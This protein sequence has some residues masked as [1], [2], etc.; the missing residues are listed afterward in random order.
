MNISTNYEFLS[1]KQQ[2]QATNNIHFQGRLP[3]FKKINTNIDIPKGNLLTIAAFAQLFGISSY[4]V[5]KGIENDEIKLS[6]NKIDPNDEENKNFVKNLLTKIRQQKNFITSSKK[7]ITTKLKQ[8]DLAKFLGVDSHSIEWHIKKGHLILGEDKTIDIT[9]PKNKSFI[10]NFKKFSKYKEEKQEYTVNDYK[11]LQKR[12]GHLQIEYCLKHQLLTADENGTINIENAINKRFL[13]LIET[14][15]IS[16]KNYFLSINE[17]AKITGQSI[18]TITRAL[19]KKELV[20]EKLG[21]D[22][23]NPQNRAF[24][25]KNTDAENKTQELK[26][27]SEIAKTLGYTNGSAIYYY[28]NLG[29]LIQE[30][31]GLININKEPNK[32]FLLE[33]SINKKTRK[34]PITTNKT[35]RQKVDGLKDGKF[36]TQTAL[37]KQLGIAQSTLLYHIMLGHLN[38][39]KGKGIDIKEDEKNITFIKNFQKNT[40][41]TPKVSTQS[42]NKHKEINFN[43]VN[44]KEFANMLSLGITT[45]SYY[46]EKGL[47]ILNKDG[48]IDLNNPTNQEFIKKFDAHAKQSFQNLAPE[49]LQK[50]KEN[51]SNFLK[52]RMSPE[53]YDVANDLYED[54]IDNLKNY[55]QYRL[56]NIVNTEELTQKQF[57]ELY[58][59]FENIVLDEIEYEPYQNPTY[60]SSTNKAELHC[61][62]YLLDTIA[63]RKIN[64]YEQKETPIAA[65]AAEDDFQIVNEIIEVKA[66]QDYIDLLKKMLGHKIELLKRLKTADKKELINA[67]LYNNFLFAKTKPYDFHRKRILN[68]QVETISNYRATILVEKVLFNYNNVRNSDKA[69]FEEWKQKIKMNVYEDLID[70]IIK[71]YKETL[72]EEACRQHAY[73]MLLE[74]N[75][76]SV[77]QF[78]EHVLQRLGINY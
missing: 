59:L 52:N 3:K 45:I 2:F 22:I 47:V 49:S 20:K 46:I 18:S 34:R 61:Y 72:E 37:A 33:L 31:N 68:K 35:R 4:F 5:K 36:I 17:F 57:D 75:Y 66:F 8:A 15:E 51:L 25:D 16:Y 29:K 58:N 19:I 64:A 55:L 38:Y 32:S 28:I 13:K 62:K 44:K 48:K 71:T 11:A 24:I 65:K 54:S 50:A 53:L 73:E 27:P 78:K 74:D 9:H 1:A 39:I 7:D 60:F 30:E 56:K 63:D 23:N 69:E 40:P 21:I 6:D 26:T 41:Q 76:I 70:K 10:D 42:Q 67:Y 43:Q 77:E 14:K 12:L